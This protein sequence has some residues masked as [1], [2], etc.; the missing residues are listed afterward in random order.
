M[1]LQ[2]RSLASEQLVCRVRA[3]YRSTQRHAGKVVDLE[4]AKLWHHCSEIA[5]E[6]IRWGRRM[7]WLLLWHEGWIDEPQAAAAALAR[8]RPAAAHPQE[9]HAGTAGRRF[10]PA[11]TG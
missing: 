3:N 2:E 8:G 4:E 11:R 5:D 1:I 6:Q 9:T 7:A 10:S